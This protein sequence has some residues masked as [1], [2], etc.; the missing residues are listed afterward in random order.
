MRAIREDTGEL[1]WTFNTPNT[2]RCLVVGQTAVWSGEECVEYRFGWPVIAD[3]EGV[4]LVRLRM[5]YQ[6]SWDF[7]KYYDDPEFPIP[8]GTEQSPPDNQGI[9]SLFTKYKRLQPVYALNLDTGKE[10]FIPLVKSSGFMNGYLNHGPMPAIRT[11]PDGQQVAYMLFSTS[12]VCHLAGGPQVFCGNRD[13]TTIGEMVLNN[14]G[15]IIGCD[16]STRPCQAGELR[17]V[18][19]Y[20]I[21]RGDEHGFMSGSGSTVFHSNWY[22]VLEGATIT[23]RRNGLGA[24]WNNPIKSVYTPFVIDQE[25]SCDCNASPS[26]YCSKGM[27]GEG[28]GSCA[29]GRVFPP[30]FY[31]HKTYNYQDTSG[32]NINPYVIVSNGYII[33]R[34]ID[35]SI[36]AIR[37][38]ELQ[39][40]GYFSQEGS[41]QISIIDNPPS[42]KVDVTYEVAYVH[43]NGTQ[44][45]IRPNVVSYHTPQA[46]LH[47]KD[48]MFL[49]NDTDKDWIIPGQKISIKGDLSTYHQ[50]PAVYIKSEDQIKIHNDS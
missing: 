46:I 3:N 50:E 30:G 19:F 44:I 7:G 16:S 22:S 45:Q 24:T 25:T 20:Y 34:N 29:V 40:L 41:S 49:P 35:A 1:A 27:L 42:E 13:D 11:L 38:G 39:T 28:R 9:K 12:K 10:A 32:W 4:V 47:R 2:Y 37:A 14:S 31:F 21:T 18:D 6:D 36:M 33:V 5:T 23:D 8:P 43:N 48:W 26:H 15:K 17:Y